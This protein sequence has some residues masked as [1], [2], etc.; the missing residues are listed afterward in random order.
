MVDGWFIRKAGSDA[1]GPY[2]FEK[3]ASGVAKLP[4]LDAIEISH[5]SET[6]GRWIPAAEVKQIQRA[7]QAMTRL[8]PP[9]P[10]AP[11][12]ANFVEAVPMR[13]PNE[14]SATQLDVPS[15]R[16]VA[17][18]HPAEGHSLSLHGRRP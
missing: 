2:N 11:I 14:L 3:I 17:V 18:Q 5:R 9:K 8:V 1:K 13:A 10:P 4:T 6:G 7:R 15:E 12:V 16:P